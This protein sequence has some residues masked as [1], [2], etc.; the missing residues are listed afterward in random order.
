MQEEDKEQVVLRP[1]EAEALSS[2]EG[3]IAVLKAQLEEFN[4]QPDEV[5]ALLQRVQADFINYKRR[6]EQE[7]EEM[8]KFFTAGLITR[9]LPIIDELGLAIEQAS[10][11]SPESNWAEG[12]RLINRKLHSVLQ[13]E[14]L[15]VIEAEGRAF[16]PQEHEALAYRESPDHQEGQVVEVTRPGYKLNGRVMRPAQVIVAKAPEAGP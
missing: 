1:E 4:R 3:E 5:R 8:L 2:P 14:G 10:V 7:R 13:S 9:L 16:D 12:V 15:T 11:S 6:S